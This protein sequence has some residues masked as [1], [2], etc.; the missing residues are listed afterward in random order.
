MHESS[1]IVKSK[2]VQNTSTSTST[3]TYRTHFLNIFC[4]IRGCPI[5]FMQP[6]RFKPKYGTTI[7]V[8]NRQNIILT[9]YLLWRQIQNI[10][11]ILYRT[12]HSLRRYSIVHKRSLIPIKILTQQRGNW[13]PPRIFLGNSPVWILTRVVKI[14]CVDEGC[15]HTKEI[16]VFPGKADVGEGV[17]HFE[18]CG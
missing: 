14:E 2:W 11:C 1:L 7:I 6:Y 3:S 5:I 18:H 8:T 4:C 13:G 17:D 12:R 9:L 15:C 10:K 16:S